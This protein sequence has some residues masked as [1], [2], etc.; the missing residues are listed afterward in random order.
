MNQNGNREERMREYLLGGLTSEEMEW[1]EEALLTDDSV[2]EELSALE[3][4]LI[5]QYIDNDLS[6][7][8]RA[9]FEQHFLVTPK[10][11]EEVSFAR[12][13][14]RY[15]SNHT[16]LT[17]AEAEISSS[18][19]QAPLRF[20]RGQNRRLAFAIAAA[21]LLAICSGVWLIPNRWRPW[22]H[23]GPQRL[24]ALTLKPGALRSGGG[25]SRIKIP[26]DAGVLE[27]R[28]EVRDPTYQAYRVVLRPFEG[29]PVFTSN[30][31]Q[32]NS[33]ETPPAVVVD[34]QAKV[35][36]AGEYQVI[37]SGVKED[38]SIEEFDDYR[39]KALR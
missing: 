6:G 26:E 24:I 35:V 3:D 25:E 12:A 2:F 7:E 39:F 21:L 32:L 9:K 13:L 27:V 22:D 29:T 14:K 16:R 4:E 30:D 37:L 31:V 11:H 34:V 17:D 18:K 28:L 36:A 5:D 38:G 8:D 15:A 23:K 19:H 33:A 20:L 10:R 1:V